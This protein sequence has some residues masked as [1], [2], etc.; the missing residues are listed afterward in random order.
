MQQD[1]KRNGGFTLV[2]LLVVLGIIAVLIAI[3]FPVI[4]GA[5]RQANLVHCAANLRS[6]GQACVTHA[7][8][9]KGYL[10]LAGTVVA[11]PSKAFVD[12]PSGLDDVERR[13]YTYSPCPGAPINM[14]VV[15]F[16]A[17]LAPY[18][19]INDLP[20]EDWIK[21]DQALNARHGVWRR[22]MCPDTDS[23][24]RANASGD[25]SDATI[26]GQGTMMMCSAGSS[27]VTVWS[28]NSDYGFN[29]GVFGYHYLPRYRKTRMGG[30]LSIVHRASEVMLFA[31]AL[32]RTSAPVPGFN[33]GWICFTPQLEPSGPVTLGDA[34][35]GNG[36]AENAESFDLNRHKGRMNVAFADGHVETVEITKESLDRIYLIPP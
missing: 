25:P 5:R 19:G 11:N 32:P 29:E 7:I 33:M 15:P 8:E 30:H 12:Y 3:L 16:P 1:P 22:F 34:F 28:T 2:E 6:I 20:M 9:K 21:L 36:R 23:L 13:Q 24:T 27:W 10:P 4:A 18:M 26:V 17:A 14:S 31:D 35:A